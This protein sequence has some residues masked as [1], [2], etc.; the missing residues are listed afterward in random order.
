MIK[1]RCGSCGQAIGVPEKFAGKHVLCPKCK[2]GIDVPQAPEGG[3]TEQPNLIRFRCPRCNQKIGLSPEYAGKQVRCAK[4]RNILRVPDGLSSLK[5]PPVSQMPSP[6]TDDFDPLDDLPDFNESLQP[7][8]SD[9]L[10]EAPLRLSPLE[11][12]SKRGEFADTTRGFPTTAGATG[13]DSH[14]KAG[15]TGLL[16]DNTLI[17]LLTSVIFVVLGGMVWGLIAKYAGMEL[18]LM[19]WGIGVLAGLGIYLFT[20]SRGTLLG[21]AAAL[22]ALFGVLSGKYFVAKWHFMPQFTAELEKHKV[23]GFIDF[24]SIKLTDEKIK[25]IMAEP[26]IMFGLVAMRLA[27]DG[28][29]TKED[30]DYYIMG[31][32]NKKFSQ[33]GQEDSNEASRQEKE[34]RHKEVETKVYKCLAEWNEQKKADVVRTQYPKMMR[35]FADVFAKSPV[36]NIVGFAVAYVAAFSFFDLIWFPLAMVTAYKFGTGESS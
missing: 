1:I 12:P 15:S 18:G 30:A 4:C 36:M 16:I 26:S 34:T 25:Q 8:R 28:K 23:S 13:G 27:D 5:P 2:A 7:K 3:G 19:A 33:K 29:I 11:K 14:S 10:T 35:E 24:N 22:I 17:A 32:F 20:A 9:A 31:K 21:V 6:P